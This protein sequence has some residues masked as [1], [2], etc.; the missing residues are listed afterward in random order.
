MEEITPKIQDTAPGPHWKHL[1]IPLVVLT[2]L[3]IGYG[4]LA[5]NYNWWPHGSTA[6]VSP[7]PS[8]STVDTT[9]WQTYR[10]E[11]YGFEFKYPPSFEVNAI[12]TSTLKGYFMSGIVVT[13]SMEG[14][15]SRF[16][17]IINSIDHSPCK[18]TS[19]PTQGRRIIDDIEREYAGCISGD[20]YHEDY[21]FD[22]N[23]SDYYQHVEVVVVYPF[24]DSIPLA[25][26]KTLNF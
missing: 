16:A 22:D 1:L 6:S 13:A 10:N 12:N 18:V 3:V 9:A 26:L 23:S 2:I 11:K 20:I 4:V 5:K 14:S 17:I 15:S 21:I 19:N 8:A 24:D 7:T 25:I